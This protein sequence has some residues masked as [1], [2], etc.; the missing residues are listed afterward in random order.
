MMPL[1][2]DFGRFGEMTEEKI[3]TDKKLF[4]MF[5]AEMCAFIDYRINLEEIENKEVFVNNLI[6]KETNKNKVH[7]DLFLEPTG[8]SYNYLNK[9][10]KEQL[11]KLYITFENIK[12]FTLDYQK[13]YIEKCKKSLPSKISKCF[14]DI[15]FIIYCHRYGNPKIDIKI[16]IRNIRDYFI[17]D[18]KK[19]IFKE[20][21]K[22]VLFD[23]KRVRRYG[24]KHFMNC[25][26]I[27]SE[28]DIKKVLPYADTITF[29]T[30][31]LETVRK[32][33]QKKSAFYFLT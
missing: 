26:T 10:E 8:I 13:K 27:K 30:V 19:D 9:E 17:L 7:F 24:R 12:S 21:R 31:S 22:K 29:D 11:K 4:L 16:F 18:K 14:D 25:W 33:F 1:F 23:E 20:F 32:A 5:C 3:K 2:Y 15:C 6:R 28:E